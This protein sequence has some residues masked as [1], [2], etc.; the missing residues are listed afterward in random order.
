MSEEQPV[1]IKKVI[2]RNFRS[3]KDLEFNVSN[4]NVFIGENNSGKT[5]ILKAL[6]LIL[7]DSWLSEKSFSDDDFYNKNMD[8]EIFIQVYFDQKISSW[9]NIQ[10]EV[11]GFQLSVGTY[12]KTTKNKEKGSIKFSYTC[13]KDDGN[14]IQVP[15]KPLKEGSGKPF[16]VPSRVTSEIKD[17]LSFVYVDVLRE[18]DKQS[19]SN[20]WSILRKLFSEINKDFQS[21]KTTDQVF[22]IDDYGQPIQKNLTRKEAFES[23]IRYALDFLKTEQFE[24]TEKILQ[25]NVTEQMGFDDEDSIKL[26][27]EGFD[28]SNAYKNLDLYVN[29]MGNECCANEVGAGLQS[30]IVLA[31]FRTFE[32]I[33]NFGSIFAIE[34]PEVFL[35][36]QKARYFES[37]LRNISTNNQVF[38]TTHSPIFVSFDN[39]ENIF[40]VRRNQ[41]FGTKVIHPENI[42][43]KEDDKKNIRLITEFDPHRN[44]MFFARK[45]V[46]V[47]GATEKIAFPLIFKALGV[48]INKEGI[49]IIDCGG[50][51]GI[52]LYMDVAN[53]FKLDYIVFADEDKSLKTKDKDIKKHQ[54]WNQEII[55]RA[56]SNYLF[57][58]PKFE[59]VFNLP[60]S[61]DSEKT[62]NA[63]SKFSSIKPEDIPPDIVNLITTFL[64][65]KP[66]LENNTIEETKSITKRK[67][68]FQ[69]EDKPSLF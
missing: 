43:E 14:V 35:H 19:P 51:P 30:A 23:Y 7:S 15:S 28:V 59:L 11:S 53:K 24:Y 58:I 37:I 36:P 68:Y 50:K 69:K 39:P 57:L 47:E 27:F 45:V 54:T 49:S 4:Y 42:F 65:K 20:R 17:A 26:F 61:D 34:E 64:S 13:I 16:F 56:T 38:I 40:I 21:N 22:I 52:P 33:N 31:I 10:I 12:K 5:N 44:E 29:Q 63:L 6:K 48:D 1:K 46:F 41:E 8:N 67:R 55:K 60:V 25:R 9:Q 66:C 2:I 62:I 3:I 32:E 18:Y